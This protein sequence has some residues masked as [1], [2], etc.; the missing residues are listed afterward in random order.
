M[1]RFLAPHHHSGRHLPHEHTSYGALALVMASATFVAVLASQVVSAQTISA[2]IEG[3]PPATAAT[4]DNLQDGQTVSVSVAAI[5]GT[6]AP[7]ALVSIYR[8]GNF[9]G[10]AAC[11]NGGLYNLSIDLQ[12]GTNSLIARQYYFPDKPGPDS[13]LV[14]VIYALPLSVIKKLPSVPQPTPVTVQAIALSITSDTQA[15]QGVVL[16]QLISWPLTIKGGTGPYQVSWNWDDGTFSTITRTT[17]GV[18]SYDH[19]YHKA[20]TFNIRVSVTDASGQV[21]Q[22]ALVA[23]VNGAAAAVVGR[24][25]PDAFLFPSILLLIPI[26]MVLIGFWL[27]KHGL[28]VFA[29]HKAQ[30]P[31]FGT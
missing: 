3:D 7:A 24:I 8:N 13:P 31:G 14:R 20:G 30:L 22:L 29:S 17:A 27:K 1:A 2:R 10:S 26:W 4:I 15:Y 5:Q 11:G 19:R 23:T 9:V 21:A 16:D 18:S 6:C 25:G 28:A 12:L